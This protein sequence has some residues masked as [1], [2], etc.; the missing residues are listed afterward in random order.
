[1][2]IYFHPDREVEWNVQKGEGNPIQYV[3]ICGVTKKVDDIAEVAGNNGAQSLECGPF[4][5]E[6]YRQGI[7]ISEANE[8]IYEERLF[9]SGISELNI[10]WVVWLMM[11]QGIVDL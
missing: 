9:T 8:K 11:D 2:H 7:R 5:E 4:T 6:E 3:A 10:I 1:M